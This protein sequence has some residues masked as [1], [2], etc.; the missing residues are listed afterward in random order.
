MWAEHAAQPQQQ[1]WGML[2]YCGFGAF[3]FYR[4]YSD[5]GFWADTICHGCMEFVADSW[6]HYPCKETDVTDLSVLGF[7]FFV[8]KR[9]GGGDGAYTSLEAIILEFG[10]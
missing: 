3:I 2:E 1:H 6:T 4:W 10:I 5:T 8:C 7:V 9:R